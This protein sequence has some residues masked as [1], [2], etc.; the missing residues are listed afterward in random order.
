MDKLYN[1]VKN[2]SDFC[3]ACAYMVIIMLGMFLGLYIFTSIIMGLIFGGF[4]GLMTATKFMMWYA[5]D[6]KKL[7]DELEQEEEQDNENN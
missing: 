5:D 1:I 4:I 6:S 2:M 7:D 3:F